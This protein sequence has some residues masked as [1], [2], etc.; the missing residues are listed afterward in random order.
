LKTEP[1]PRPTPP[2]P[3]SRPAAPA[4]PKARS[5]PAATQPRSPSSPAS[6]EARAGVPASWQKFDDR[7][8]AEFKARLEAFAGEAGLDPD[9]EFRGGEGQLFFSRQS[10]TLALK[11]WFRAQVSRMPESIRRV[12]AAG[13][14]I[15]ANPELAADLEVVA[16]RERGGDWI[17]R[18]FDPSSLPV[19]AFP[20]DPAI[21]AVRARVI[22]PWRGP[23]IPCCRTC[24]R[25]SESPR[26]TFIG[27]DRETSS[28]SS[29][30]NVVEPRISWADLDAWAALR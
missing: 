12:R 11:R 24:S 5:R 4:K 17:L 28:S 6:A 27:R 30:C 22:R 3:G 13:Q 10:Q 2:A 16:V 1:A 18:D 8:H 14:A 19:S 21:Q 9:L 15:A 26:P 25:R 29:I 23:P 7:T 20:G